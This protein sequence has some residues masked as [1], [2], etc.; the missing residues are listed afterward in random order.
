MRFPRITFSLRALLLALGLVALALGLYLRFGEH[1]AWL[2]HEDSRAD[3]KPIPTRPLIAPPPEEE[4]LICRIGPLEFEIPT[5]VSAKV[6]T[7]IGTY[8]TSLMIYEDMRVVS[9]HLPNRSSES[10]RARLA[11][12]PEKR[13]LTYPRLQAEAAGVQSSDFSFAMSPRELRW[14][15]WLMGERAVYENDFD[16]LEYQWRPELEGCLFAAGPGRDFIWQSVDLQWSG[17]FLFTQLGDDDA[18]IRRVCATFTLNGD[19]AELEGL[20]EA[21]LL[22]LIEFLEPSEPPAP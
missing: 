11:E 2:L 3:L 16:F 14:H 12:F 1:M 22:A 8:S 9:V 15:K 4:Y 13:S 19:P 18:W 6:R 17:S 20:T 7:E 10:F 21:E 5:A